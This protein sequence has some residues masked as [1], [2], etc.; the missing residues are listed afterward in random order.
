MGE[1]MKKVR[2]KLV[3]NTKRVTFVP[4]IK[5]KMKRKL[6]FAA[7]IL[8]SLFVSSRSWAGEKSWQKVCRKECK[9]LDK[10]GWEVFGKAQTLEE[11]L[12]PYYEG[13]SSDTLLQIVVTSEGNNAN[14]ALSRARRM[15]SAE[16]AAHR[17]TQVQSDVTVLTAQTAEGDSVASREKMNASTKTFTNQRVR[18]FTPLVTLTRKL[19][20]G[21]QEV[22]LYYL[23]DSPQ[24]SNTRK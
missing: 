12:A 7:V 23:Y 16:Y 6:F 13:L 19:P 9:V 1:S 2:E 3:C 14:M 18:A 11:A 20:N 8:L 17:E 10:E 5:E 15:A 24:I 4:K 22:R 21:K